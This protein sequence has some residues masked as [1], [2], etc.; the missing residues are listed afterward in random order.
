MSTK[1]GNKK[2]PES[3][4]DL[5]TQVATIM[6]Q[7]NRVIRSMPSPEEIQR[8]MPRAKNLIDVVRTAEETEYMHKL[9]AKL[10]GLL[11]RTANALK[12]EPG[13]TTLHDWSDLPKVAAALRKK[14]GIR[15]GQN[16]A[17]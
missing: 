6:C 11:T 16:G 10:S 12:G 7:C 9:L 15:S 8:M 2:V 13:P 17:S 1:R 14:A 3:P 4:T 5:E